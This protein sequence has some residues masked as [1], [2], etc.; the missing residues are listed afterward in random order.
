MLVLSSRKFSTKTKP[1]KKQNHFHNPKYSK[2]EIKPTY[3]IKKKEN[4]KKIF[5]PVKKKNFYPILPNLIKSISKK[6]KIILSQGKIRQKFFNKNWKKQ[7]F[8][9]KNFRLKKKVNV[10]KDF[11]KF[12]KK[13]NFRYVRMLKKFVF[14]PK[15]LRTRFLF[16]L[17][18]ITKQAFLQYYRFFSLK[19]FQKIKKL[20]KTKKLKLTKFEK[21]ILFFEMRLTCVL[22]RI[23]YAKYTLYSNFLIL[24]G[25]I[26]VNGSRII[27]CDYQIK[28]FDLIE[29]SYIAFYRQFFKKYIFRKYYRYH[30]RFYGPLYRFRTK[31]VYFFLKKKFKKLPRWL[32]YTV[33][34][35]FKS[36]PTFALFSKCPTNDYFIQSPRVLA[37]IIY[38]LPF[39]FK[40]RRLPF[41]MTKKHM[42]FFSNFCTSFA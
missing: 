41:F 19:N 31:Y 21:F 28:L 42:K 15:K 16:K 20:Y 38:K 2:V 29:I 4:F 25:Q 1:Y 34:R 35:V 18:L 9:K 39:R 13:A 27:F 7:K 5:N 32:F 17:M 12:K 33:I 24:N 14:Y 37:T 11:R 6:K 8:F 26:R 10:K 23:R 40:D 22:V 30:L 36:I 3:F